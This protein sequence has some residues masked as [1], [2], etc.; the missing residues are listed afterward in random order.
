MKR[1]IKLYPIPTKL[2]RHPKCFKALPADLRSNSMQ[3]RLRQN[4]EPSYAGANDELE[5]RARRLF[6]H[7]FKRFFRPDPSSI[8]SLP[9]ELLEIVADWIRPSVFATQLMLEFSACEG[10]RFRQIKS[11][12]MPE[13]L[14]R[15]CFSDGVALRLS[16][17]E[18]W[19]AKYITGLSVMDG[20]K[21]ADPDIVVLDKTGDWEYLVFTLD[22]SGCQSVRLYDGHTVPAVSGRWHRALSKEQIFL[23]GA[24]LARFQGQ[25]LRDVT[26]VAEPYAALYDTLPPPSPHR[27]VESRETFQRQLTPPR[28]RQHRIPSHLCGVSM[29]FHGGTTLDF[30]LHRAGD[31]DFS[32]FRDRVDRLRFQPKIRYADIEPGEELVDIAVRTDRT[33]LGTS[34][35]C[36]MVRLH[37]I[38]LVSSN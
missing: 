1:A 13:R 27:T 34:T 23:S 5:V 31:D 7:V 19:T 6:A 33:F 12:P 28:V 29:A 11:P 20:A 37:M 14:Q 38:A 32:S 24:V 10:A 3:D 30:H 2:L 21:A 25:T 8:P 9:A 4:A 22:V 18:V 16:F 15:L 35:A 17:D 36:L 26:T